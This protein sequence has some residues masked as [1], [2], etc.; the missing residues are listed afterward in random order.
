MRALLIAVMLLL[1]PVSLSAAETTTDDKVVIFKKSFNKLINSPE[2]KA[3]ML[4]G[5]DNEKAIKIFS[6]EA[7][8]GSAS[9]QFNLGALYAGGHYN[10]KQD[11]DKAVSL[12]KKSAI[13]GHNKAQLALGV[14]YFEGKG[15]EQ[16]Y[17]EALNWLQKAA[18]Q[19]NALAYKYLSLIYANGLGVKIDIEEAVKW[20]RKAINNGDK[21]I[22][23]SSPKVTK[24]LA[25]RGH[26]TA[27]YYLAIRRFLDTTENSYKKEAI[28][29]LR[30][31][32]NNGYKK[33]ENSMGIAYKKGMGVTQDYKEAFKWF[34]K[35]AE[36]KY[37]GGVKEY[38]NA[39]A[40]NNL[41]LMYTDGLGVERDSEKAYFWFSLSGRQGNVLAQKNA[42]L[43]EKKINPD[44]LK[45]YKSSLE[46][47]LETYYR[48]LSKNKK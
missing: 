1:C 28:K 18:S 12:F 7:H 43:I 30:K 6:A 9:A 27:Q 19:K 37:V 16:D 5:K 25:E 31:S 45:A 47:Y 17:K 40:Q 20:A 33:A 4:V 32:A 41:G 46:D 2:A 42:R 21:S 11:Y 39:E 8:K 44:K 13:Q 34:E 36:I 3:I 38:G 24:L 23:L 15:V 48:Y 10:I 14:L 35:S 26:S 29:W 22:L